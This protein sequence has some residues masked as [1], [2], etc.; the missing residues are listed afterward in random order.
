MAHSVNNQQECCST[1]CGSR[2]PELAEGLEALSPAAL[3]LLTAIS[4]RS[5]AQA[6]EKVEAD[7]A[8]SKNPQNSGVSRSGH[9]YSTS[10]PFSLFGVGGLLLSSHPNPASAKVSHHPQRNRH[11]P[12]SDTSF[13]SQTVPPQLSDADLWWDISVDY[14]TCVP[15]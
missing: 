9:L 15:R 12:S 3:Q 4:L 2:A 14:P 10:S 13:F 8:P 7:S 11:L 1:P 5:P 6:A